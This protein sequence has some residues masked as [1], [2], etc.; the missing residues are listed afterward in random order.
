MN[1]GQTRSRQVPVKD[2]LFTM[3][4]TPNEAAHLIGGKCAECGEI[5]F[6]KRIYCAK[7]TSAAV[8][9]V[10]L[11]T[12]GKVYTFSIVRGTPPGSLI[13]APYVIAEVDLDDGASVLTVLTDC[14]SDDVAFGMEVRL[15]IEKIGN[16][17]AGNDI[18]AFKFAPVGSAA[19]EGG[20]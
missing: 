12:T 7:C 9:E 1:V 17:E 14:N 3:P 2:G 6:P 19:N 20:V 4:S 16:D 5:S 15:V 10:P 11:S 18:M 8:Q 13:E